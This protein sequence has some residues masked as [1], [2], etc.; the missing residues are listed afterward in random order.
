MRA[1]AIAAVLLLTPS[2]VLEQRNRYEVEQ[3]DYISNPTP[4]IWDADDEDQWRLVGDLDAGAVVTQQGCQVGDWAAHIT[5]VTLVSTSPNLQAQVTIEGG[6]LTFTQTAVPVKIDSKR[7]RYQACIYG[8]D[9]DQSSPLLGPIGDG[10]GVMWTSS[11]R[12]ANPTGR[13]VRDVVATF[14]IGGYVGP[15]T[16]CGT[17]PITTHGQRVS[18]DPGI[19][20]PS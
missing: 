3:Q 2:F 17:Y 5:T 14:R 11:V 15:N 8:P 1:L 13:R 12:V 18:W 20:L 4:C 16:I 6:G 10:Q 9:Y 7:Y 19:W